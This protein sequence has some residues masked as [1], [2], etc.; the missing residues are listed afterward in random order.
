MA[1]IDVKPNLL[2]VFPRIMGN[3]HTQEIVRTAKERDEYIELWKNTHPIYISVYPFS[4]IFTDNITKTHLSA[5]VRY[6]A[7][8]FDESN[9]YSEMIRMHNMLMHQNI[10]HRI[11][12]SGRGFHVFVW[13]KNNLK[14][15]KVA[16]ANYW[17]YVSDYS[18]KKYKN[19]FKPSKTYNSP[20]LTVCRSTRGDLGRIIRYPNTFNFGA[21]CFCIVIDDYILNNYTSLLQIQ[22]FAKKPYSPVGNPY[23]GE[24][25]LDISE[26]D[27]D[28]KQYITIPNGNLVLN[29]DH[30]T[31]KINK[32]VDVDFSDVPYCIKYIIENKEMHFIERNEVIKFFINRFG[33]FPYSVDDVMGILFKIGKKDKW[34]HWFFTH[35][36][37]DI[38]YRNV[39]VVKDNW[40]V[41]S[42]CFKM[43][44]LGFCDRELCTWR[45]IVRK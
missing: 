30:K 20:R 29:L 42:G 35:H 41:L 6:L 11:H 10:I 16:M 24:N 7:F 3:P 2:N 26:F 36:R 17:D 19:P 15:P 23:F 8:D 32:D 38:L 39:K 34:L 40:D 1:L 28:S 37:E 12:L 43:K 44:Q 14:Y 18:K 5:R 22:N 45:D 33:D 13:I 9:A 31:I 25:E 21:N 4:H 27:C